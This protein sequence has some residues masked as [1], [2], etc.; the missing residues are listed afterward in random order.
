[1]LYG[2]HRCALMW[3]DLSMGWTFPYILATAVADLQGMRR[4]QLSRKPFTRTSVC[5][6]GIWGSLY[7]GSALLAYSDKLICATLDL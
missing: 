7:Y 5:Y 3:M 4:H 1:M 6:R 2:L